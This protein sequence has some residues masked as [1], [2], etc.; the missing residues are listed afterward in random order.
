MQAIFN[1]ISNFFSWF[2]D[3]AKAL[4]EFVWTIID[5]NLDLL[6]LIP[7][8]T[9]TLTD[10][11]GSLPPVLLTFAAATITVSVVFLIVNRSPGGSND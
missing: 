4:I 5:G 8:A 9:K 2:V 6:Q 1:N 10:S 11:L 3:T 7:Q